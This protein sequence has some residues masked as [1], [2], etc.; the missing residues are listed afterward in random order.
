V[1]EESPVPSAIRKRLAQLPLLPHQILVGGVRPLSVYVREGQDVL[2]P[3]VV[4]W[5]DEHTG[6]VRGHRLFVPENTVVGAINEAVLGLCDALVGPTTSRQAG[7][8]AA[9]EFVDRPGLPGLI[10]VDDAGLAQGVE[11][12][13]GPLGVRV[14]AADALPLLDEAAASLD[15]HLGGDPNASPPKPFSWSIDRSLLSPLYTAAMAFGKRAPWEYL[16]DMPPIAV[17]LGDDGPQRN[18]PVLYGCVLGAAG[19]VEGIAF[20]YSLRQVEKAVATGEILGIEEA[21]MDAAAAALVDELRQGG[22]PVDD[23]PPEVL[24]DAVAQL[25][26]QAQAGATQELQDALALYFED[27]READ[28]TY[29][30]WMKRQGL[31]VPARGN[32][33][34]FW[35]IR[36][37]GDPR[38][39]NE[40]EVRA[41]TLALE[42]TN[43]FLSRHRRELARDVFPYEPLVAA[44]PTPTGREIQV[45]WPGDE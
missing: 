41:L 32:V 26:V 24:R 15:T 7:D 1:K 21:D 10:R 35:R 43:G 29:L 23:V 39:P 5:L 20:Y 42:A 9:S 36:R 13:L 28:P 22:F 25:V 27:V 45:Q 37:R 14:E 6:L 4:L 30:E 17:T 33:P 38:P 16:D 8:R 11:R 34:M 31:T 44:I 18:R 3:S 40:R 19:M 2:R 12:L